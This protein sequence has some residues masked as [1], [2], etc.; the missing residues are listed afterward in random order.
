MG[1]GAGLRGALRRLLWRARG[2]GGVQD[3]HLALLDSL[4]WQEPLRGMTYTALD[5]E[6]TGLDPKRD[7]ILSVGAVRIRDGR[8]V[9]KERFYQVFKP[10][11]AVSPKEIV[12]IH[13]LGD[14]EV[15]RASSLGEALEP[16]LEFLGETVLVGHF[17]RIDLDFLNAGLQRHGRPALQN[18]AL[19][20]RLLYRWLMRHRGQPDLEQ[21]GVE[22]LEA[23]V[24]S[25]GLPRFPAHQAYYD[26]LSAGLVFLKLQEEFERAGRVQF[27]SLFREA[28]VY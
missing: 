7:E 6:M 19:D 12:L 18:A 11:A 28:G 14:E 5:C 27:Q 4:E 1:E 26:A 22:R 17:V 16:L 8:A 20:T 3:A 10:D 15:G 9:L 23:I 25:L 2:A 21:P 13:G 24:E